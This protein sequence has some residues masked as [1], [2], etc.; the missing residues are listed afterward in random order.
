MTLQELIELKAKALDAAGTASDA[1]ALE[2][3]RIEYLARKGLLPK[4]MLELKNVAPEDK[5]MFGKTVN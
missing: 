4:V 1:A 5:P 2:T 3:V